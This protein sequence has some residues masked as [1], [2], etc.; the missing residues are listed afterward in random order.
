MKL[1]YQIRSH[2][3]PICGSRD[4]HRSKR[5]GI[6]EQLACRITPVRPFRCN[7]CNARIYA[8]EQPAEKSA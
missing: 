1:L 6:A 2:K 3:C 8:Y 4:I 7:S 5:R